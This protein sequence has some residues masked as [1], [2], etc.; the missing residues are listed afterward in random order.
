MMLM[1]DNNYNIIVKILMHTKY[2]NN[3]RYYVGTA[4]VIRLS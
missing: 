3:L 2:D 4:Y 1:Y